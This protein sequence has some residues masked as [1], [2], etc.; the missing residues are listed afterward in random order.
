MCMQ[1]DLSKFLAPNQ[2][3]AVAVSGGVDSV[4]L[5]YFMLSQ[6]E[7]YH[8]KI[9][10]VNVE[11]GIRGQASKDDTNFVESLCAKLG[12]KLYKYSVDSLLKA[13]SDKLSLEEAARILRYDCFF[14][15][16]SKGCCDKVATAHHLSDNFESVILNL[17]RGTGLKGVSGIESNYNDKI[18]RP[19]LSVSKHQIQDYAL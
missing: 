2:T 19:F 13:K 9:V 10:A 6:A 16:I 7:K 1:I 12:V 3:V 5:L 14:D 4:A 8:I 15:L 11:H 17:F 18:I